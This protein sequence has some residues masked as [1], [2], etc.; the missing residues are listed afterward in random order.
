MTDTEI[1]VLRDEA[2]AL[3]NAVPR[4]TAMM[5]HAMRVCLLHRIAESLELIAAEIAAIESLEV[6]S[7]VV[8][9]RPADHG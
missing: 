8:G 1:A 4:E 7:A 3:V 2:R 5:M 9:D 6:N